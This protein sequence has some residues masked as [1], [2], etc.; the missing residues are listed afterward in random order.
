MSYYLQIILYLC[1]YY[2]LTHH[3]IQERVFTL[4]LTEPFQFGKN[5][6]Y[7][8]KVQFLIK[9]TKL[10]TKPTFRRSTSLCRSS[11]AVCTPRLPLLSCSSVC[12]NSSFSRSLRSISSWFQMGRFSLGQHSSL[13][14]LEVSQLCSFLISLFNFMSLLL[15]LRNSSVYKCIQH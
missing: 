5:F 13:F 2:P 6:K 3:R 8:F 4:Y 9:T 10:L 1:T 11:R 12:L 7:C 15:V 14:N